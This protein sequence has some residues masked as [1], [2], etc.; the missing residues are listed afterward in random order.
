M[1]FV[2]PPRVFFVSLKFGGFAWSCPPPPPFSLC[3][4]FQVGSQ[5]LCVRCDACWWQSGGLLSDP[6][7]LPMLLNNKRLF[8]HSQGDSMKGSTAGVGRRGVLWQTW[9]AL[10][11]VRSSYYLSQTPNSSAVVSSSFFMPFWIFRP[12]SLS[13]IHS[14]FLSE[15]IGLLSSQ[16]SFSS[17]LY[18]LLPP[19]STSCFFLFRFLSYIC[20]HVSP[21]PV[22]FHEIHLL[23]TTFHVLFLYSLTLSPSISFFLLPSIM[24]ISLFFLPFSSSLSVSLTMLSTKEVISLPQL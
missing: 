16:A 21:F 20:R 12:R 24:C 2:P 23:L 8:R 22:S 11:E 4:S 7:D 5:F 17:C 15:S 9:L 10:W 19:T 6:C 14:S 3:A 18:L 1:D 13:S